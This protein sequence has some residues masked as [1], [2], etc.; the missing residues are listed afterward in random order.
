ME[1]QRIDL[2]S[3]F[4]LEFHNDRVPE[5]DLGRPLQQKPQLDFRL[6]TNTDSK[7]ILFSAFF[8]PNPLE[9]QFHIG[10]PRAWSRSV[11]S[12]ADHHRWYRYSGVETADLGFRES[13]S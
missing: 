12:L 7:T 2:V 3:L 5:S 6:R 1:Y 8:E 4:D 9:G 10:E 11:L 13:L